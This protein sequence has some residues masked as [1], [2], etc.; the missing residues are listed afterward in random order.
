M[1]NSKSNVSS[2]QS[3]KEVEND[4]LDNNSH[5]YEP[6][7]PNSLELSLPEDFLSNK[8]SSTTCLPNFEEPWFLGSSS[9]VDLPTQQE[10]LLDLP[11][12]NTTIH[13]TKSADFIPSEDVQQHQKT[14]QHKVCCPVCNQQFSVCFIEEHAN[15]CL[16][17]RS[18]QLFSKGVIEINSDSE[19]EQHNSDNHQNSSDTEAEPII[20][21]TLDALTR[22]IQAVIASCKMEKENILQLNI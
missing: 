13:N 20:Q 10:L 14:D 16:E 22:K 17:S 15:E 1:K 2:S 19:S 8:S 3:E 5:S 18:R 11:S 12:I 7:I 4:I 6:G 9:S 21:E